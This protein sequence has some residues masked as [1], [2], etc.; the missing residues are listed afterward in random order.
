MADRASKRRAAWLA[1]ATTPRPREPPTATGSPRSAPPSRRSTDAWKASMSTWMISRTGV[2]T[3]LQ[4]SRRGRPRPPRAAGPGPPRAG[5]TGRRRRDTA[6]PAAAPASRDPHPAP[7]AG[8]TKCR[9]PFTWTVCPLMQA[10]PTTIS[11]ACAT[12]SGEP[13][14]PIG[15]VPAYPSLPGAIMSVSISDGATALTVTPSLAVRA[16]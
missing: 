6:A 16:A 8:R 3:G 14:R 4:P 5:G 13:R 9:P 15:T 1:A 11:T 7:R 12:S 10:S 2:V